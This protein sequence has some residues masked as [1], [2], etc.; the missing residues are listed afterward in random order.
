MDKRENS[1]EAWR[2]K[3]AESFADFSAQFHALDTFA[4]MPANNE[5]ENKFQEGSFMTSLE[6]V[7]KTC[8]KA[9][10][11]E[12]VVR[13]YKGFFIDH[14]EALQNNVRGK[15]AIINIDCDLEQSTRDALEISRALIQTGTVILFDD[16]NCFNA[17]RN[18]GQRK[19]FVDFR[20]KTAFSFDP[21]FSY[22]FGGQAFL[23][24]G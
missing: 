5:D 19:A 13:F 1:D 9:G 24:T 21:W 8:S 20:S 18:R 17:D 12:S 14:K 10:L 7:S 23:C 4:G 11:T 22:S 16:Y 2:R 6:G 3:G 15:A